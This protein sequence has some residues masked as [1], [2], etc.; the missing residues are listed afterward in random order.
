MKY[1]R[2]KDGIFD[3]E[4][5]NTVTKVYETPKGMMPC[6]YSD[7]TLVQE[8]DR[9]I[10]RNNKDYKVTDEN[11]ADTIEELM[12][13]GDLVFKKNG[14]TFVIPNQAWIDYYIKHKSIS[15]LFIEDSRGNYI[16]VAEENEQGDLELI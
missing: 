9:F 11:T 14:D 6:M 10:T 4:D 8:G 5:V 13:V 15:K 1:I 16:K 2:T 7:G 12:M 3:F